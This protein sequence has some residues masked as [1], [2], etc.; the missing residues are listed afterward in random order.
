VIIGIGREALY[1][2]NVDMS[3][4]ACC[5][6]C[7]VVATSTAFQNDVFDPDVL[8]ERGLHNK[9]TSGEEGFVDLFTI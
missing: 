3:T 4:D 8:N 1:P 2:K 7:C 9:I 5:G 6:D